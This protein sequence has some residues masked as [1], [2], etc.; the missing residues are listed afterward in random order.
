MLHRVNAAQHAAALAP[1]E[2]LVR[3]ELDVGARQADVAEHA[4][5]EGVQLAA[6]AR[7]I[8]P[9]R[10]Q[11]GQGRGDRPYRSRPSRPWVALPAACMPSWISRQGQTWIL[12]SR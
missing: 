6:L 11:L 12:P 3:L 8:E 1:P 9:D 4:V 2:M 7:P 10:E 5:V